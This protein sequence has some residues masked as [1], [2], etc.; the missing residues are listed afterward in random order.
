MELYNEIL[1][2]LTDHKL[3]KKDA[4]FV[5]EMHCY[6]ALKKIKAILEDDSLDDKE[7]FYKIEEMICLLENMGSSG[8]SRHDFG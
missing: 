3:S 5:V 8:G 2:A 4:D 6:M 7:C 1:A